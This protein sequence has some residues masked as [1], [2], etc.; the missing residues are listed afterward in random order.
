M[1]IPPRRMFSYDNNEVFV[2]DMVGVRPRGYRCKGD[3]SSVIS[4]G[5]GAKCT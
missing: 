5:C 1:A 2:F 4:Q 3:K